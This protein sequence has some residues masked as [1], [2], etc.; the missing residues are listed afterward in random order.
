MGFLCD[1]IQAEEE[2]MAAAAR[3]P[4][5]ASPGAKMYRSKQHERIAAAGQSRFRTASV[6]K[7]EP[8]IRN[9]SRIHQQENHAPEQ[10]QIF[11]I[12]NPCS[13]KPPK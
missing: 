13:A 7:R 4:I 10:Q 11:M 6:N 2:S 9:S 3:A 8:R 12:R 1:A 5:Q